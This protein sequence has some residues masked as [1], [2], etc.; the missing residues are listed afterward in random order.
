MLSI[1][2]KII[3]LRRRRHLLHFY[4]KRNRQRLNLAPIDMLRPNCNLREFSE[5][6][7]LINPYALQ[8][9]TYF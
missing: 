1:D 2:I 3:G 6:N 9:K 5:F 4:H 8:Q 7:H